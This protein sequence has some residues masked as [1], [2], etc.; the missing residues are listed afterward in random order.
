MVEDCIFCRIVAH[1]APAFICYEDDQLMVFLDL[2][3]VA[4][5]HTLIIPKEHF[6][7]LFV[8][9]PEL[10]AAVAALSVR[11]AHALRKVTD[12]EGIGVYQLNGAAAG[13][14]VFHYHVHL[15]P[16]NSG[17]SLEMHSRVKGDPQQLQVL[18]DRLA[19]A[20]RAGDG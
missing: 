4:E 14:T 8:A 3:P 20:L 16:R 17:G 7:D 1:E 11:V 2:F 12:C 5:G 6:S 10:V 13:Q 18:A 9:R 15:I 19:S